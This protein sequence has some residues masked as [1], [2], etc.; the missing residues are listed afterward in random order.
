VIVGDEIDLRGPVG[1]WFVW[2]GESPALLVGGGSGVVPL[3]AMLRVARRAGT[4][5]LVRLVVSART[6][7]DLY[8]TTEILGRETT[9]V[10][11][12]GTPPAFA[13]PAGR[14]RAADIPADR[15]GG[16]TCYVCGSPAFCDAATDLLIDLGAPAERIR[17]ERFGPTG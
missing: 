12:R 7:D 1:E 11:T 6:P 8:Y 3:M 9:I 16:S 4:S 14:L 10:Y 5:D 13:R 2:D 17:V 15:I